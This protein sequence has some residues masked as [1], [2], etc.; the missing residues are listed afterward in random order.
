MK[1]RAR[2]STRLVTLD[3]ADARLFVSLNPTVRIL[4]STSFLNRRRTCR[5]YRMFPVF[6][7]STGSF[8]FLSSACQ[9]NGGNDFVRVASAPMSLLVRLVVTLVGTMVV[10]VLVTESV[11]LVVTVVATLVVKVVVTA[12]VTVLVILL[13]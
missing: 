13:V 8:D 10:T 11:A 2:V 3:S 9:S 5:L 4:A 12:V 7:S 1:S 6:C